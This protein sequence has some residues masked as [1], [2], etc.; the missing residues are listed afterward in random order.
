LPLVLCYHVVMSPIGKPTP[1]YHLLWQVG[2]DYIVGDD[3]GHLG[4]VTETEYDNFMANRRQGYFTG[5]RKRVE[6]LDGTLLPGNRYS[7]LKVAVCTLHQAGP[8]WVYCGFI[9]DSPGWIISG[10]PETFP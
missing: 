5:F 3:A 8:Y 10:E 1:P 4:V 9:R 7:H 6:V 2:D